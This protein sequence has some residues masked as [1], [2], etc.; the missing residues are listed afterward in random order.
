MADAERSP[1][2]MATMTATKQ[3]IKYDEHH[4]KDPSTGRYQDSPPPNL[5]TLYNQGPPSKVC[6]RGPINS[7][8]MQDRCFGVYKLVP[9]RYVNG[10]PSWEHQSED[11]ILAITTVD[12]EEMWVVAHLPTFGVKP[13][14]SLKLPGKTMPFDR[15]RADKM[16]QEWDGRQWAPANGVAC[17][18][19]HHGEGQST[20][21]A[22][23]PHPACTVHRRERRTV[24]ATGWGDY[25]MEKH[26]EHEHHLE[27]HG[28]PT[29]RAR[30]SPPNSPPRY[31]K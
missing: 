1:K 29:S 20:D 26:S 10:Y 18:V 25:G 19:N 12:N 13:R 6:I 22:Q 28:S 3:G 2:W 9:A 21:C 7:L 15:H 16:W 11:L 4:F 8:K 23:I 30:K 5:K 14:I 17:K 24:R 27:R 31:D